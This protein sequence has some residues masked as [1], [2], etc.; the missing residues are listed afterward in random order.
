MTVAS[1]SIRGGCRSLTM[2]YTVIH[3]PFTLKFR[4]M[5]KKELRRY[6]EWFMDV[7]PLR[8]NELANAVKQTPGFEAWE[9]DCT[10]TSLDRLGEWFASQVETR[11][12]TQ[13]EFQT[14]QNRQIFQIDV[15]SEELTNRTFSLAMD[16]GMYFS[17][18]LLK[19]H[20]SLKWEQPLKN[21]KFIDYGQPVLVKF[22]PGP[23]NP[24]GMMV[25]FAYGLISKKKTGE[26]LRN[27]YNI[28]SKL[29]QP[30]S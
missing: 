6:Y 25:T 11:N 5:P 27:I 26:G 16:I 24:A 22:S 2:P 18:V 10:P 3:P 17:Q 1:H 19:N 13:S 21:K 30:T 15:P 23:F 14:I 4:E 29:V 8:V 9:S 20:P 7:L 28:W 12:R